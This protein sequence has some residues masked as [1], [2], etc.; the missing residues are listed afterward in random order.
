MYE[1]MGMSY[2]DDA[3]LIGPRARLHP[4]VWN[5]RSPW[6][7]YRVARVLNDGTK[8]MRPKFAPGG[9]FIRRA[10]RLICKTVARLQYVLKW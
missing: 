2:Y 9:K 10:R 6:A 3:P 8:V 4:S 5:K 1:E 7:R